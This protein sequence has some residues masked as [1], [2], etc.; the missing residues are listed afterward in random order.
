MHDFEPQERTR[1]G[2][3]IF[4]YGLTYTNYG[5]QLARPANGTSTGIAWSLW[6]HSPKHAVG[7]A[8]I[9]EWAKPDDLDITLQSFEETPKGPIFSQ[10]VG[11]VTSMDG[12]VRLVPLFQITRKTQ[13]SMTVT[14]MGHANARASIGLSGYAPH[15][16]IE[17]YRSAKTQVVAATFHIQLEPKEHRTLR[18]VQEHFNA[19]GRLDRGPGYDQVTIDQIRWETFPQAVGKIRRL[20][21]E[22]EWRP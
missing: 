3:Q 18:G 15:P 14:N 13:L 7:I 8:K 1:R 19:I 22:P 16:G 10:N 21:G 17:A 20:H 4:G 11:A 6:L 12:Q 5:E 9:H 2:W